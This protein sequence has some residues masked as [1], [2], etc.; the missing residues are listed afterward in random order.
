[1]NL[2]IRLTSSAIAYVKKMLTTSPESLGIRVGVKKSGCSGFAYVLDFAKVINDDDIVIPTDNIQVVINQ[3]SLPYLKGME[4]DCHEDEMQQS[5][6]KF[7]NP[8]VKGE[9]GCGESFSV[10]E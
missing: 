4:I 7:K 10:D 8:N 3:E 5:Y 6:L 9:C 2:N 1:M